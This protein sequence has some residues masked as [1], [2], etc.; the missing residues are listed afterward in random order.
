MKKIQE[1]YNFKIIKNKKNI[2]ARIKAVLSEVT[3]GRKN[4]KKLQ[5][6]N[7]FLL[8]NTRLIVN[9]KT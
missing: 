1:H 7:D 9:Y 5:L 4:G 3:E 2:L 8:E 6:L